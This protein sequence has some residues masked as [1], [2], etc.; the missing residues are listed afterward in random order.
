MGT[1]CHVKGGRLLGDAVGWKLGISVGQRTSDGRFDF[2]RVNCLGC[3]AI[4]PVV[5][6][7][8][9]TL[10]RMMVTRLMKVMEEHE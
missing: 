7:N 1:A 6:V 5:Q 3:C 4:A 2:Q 8:E 10:G 9:R